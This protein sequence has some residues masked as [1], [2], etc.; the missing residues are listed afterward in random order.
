VYDK[1]VTYNIDIE[2]ESPEEAYEIYKEA[3]GFAGDFG[4]GEIP[5]SVVN[6]V[7]REDRVR[8]ESGKCAWEFEE[9]FIS[10]IR[11]PFRG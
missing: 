10:C 9:P 4:T 8:I 11:V 1:K 6:G 5:G 3:R 2:A 7:H